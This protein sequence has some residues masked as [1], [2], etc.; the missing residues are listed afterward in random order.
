MRDKATPASAPLRN[1]PTAATGCGAAILAGGAATRMGGVQKGLLEVSGRPILDLALEVLGQ[2]FDD[3]M[4][5]CKEPEPLSGYLAGR[6]GG[7]R[8]VQDTFEARSSLTGIHAALAAARTPH[9]FVMAC[10]TPLLRPALLAALLNRL[11]PEHDVVLP[12]KPDGYFEPLCAL[13]SLRCLPHI[14]AQLAAGDYKIIRFFDKVHVSPL[15]VE[16]LLRADPLL[17]SFQNANSPSDLH[18]LRSTAQ[19]LLRPQETA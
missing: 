9:V 10:D 3:I 16:E 5:V 19:A 2:F 1:G 13:Y 11:R 8:A 7:V 6:A 14:A 15:P 17:V 4:V 18:R 12:Q